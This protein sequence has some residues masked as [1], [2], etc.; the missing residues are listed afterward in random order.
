MITLVGVPTSAH[1]SEVVNRRPPMGP[2]GGPQRAIPYRLR[3]MCCPSMGVPLL[4]APY[5]RS[6]MG[7]PL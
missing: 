5:G 4:A 6:P 1:V 7:G 3:P 2:M